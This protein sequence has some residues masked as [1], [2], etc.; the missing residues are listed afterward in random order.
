[1]L[2]LFILISYVEFD[3]DLYIRIYIYMYKKKEDKLL[4]NLFKQF[5]ILLIHFMVSFVV[6]IEIP[7]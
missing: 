5:N 3:D 7:I 1:M 6:S 2:K 4:K